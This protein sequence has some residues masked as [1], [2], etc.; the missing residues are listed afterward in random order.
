M[1]FSNN[2]YNDRLYA[3]VCHVWLF[4]VFRAFRSSV[5]CAHGLK[6]KCPDTQHSDIETVVADLINVAE[7]CHQ[8]KLYEGMYK[9]GNIH[10]RNNNTKIKNSWIW[11]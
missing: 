1:F 3:Y 7:L 6:Q 10:I 11:N 9:N 5:T 4:D 2:M 8:P